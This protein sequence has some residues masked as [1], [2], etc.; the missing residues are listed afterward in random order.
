MEYLLEAFQG[1]T[2]VIISSYASRGLEP[3]R[4]YPELIKSIPHIRKLGLSTPIYILGSDT[5]HYGVGRTKK[6]PPS[7]RR[8][9]EQYLASHN[10]T[11]VQHLG[12]LSYSKYLHILSK[13]RLHIHI[14]Q[15]FVPSW[16]LLDSMS[17]GT[18]VIA[19]HNPFTHQLSQIST[20]ISL[21]SDPYNPSLFAEEVYDSY[22]SS[23]QRPNHSPSSS[24]HDIFSLSSCLSQWIFNIKSLVSK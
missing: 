21:A 19:S 14:T 18:P 24:F 17:F 15:P 1:L 22:W 13:A 10:I 4:C 20:N 7:Y 12:K 8:W 23:S 16:S 6:Q 3:M 11:N 2:F 5:V 9:G